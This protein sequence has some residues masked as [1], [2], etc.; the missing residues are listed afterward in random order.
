MCVRKKVLVTILTIKRDAHRSADE[1]A[2]RII[3]LA[4]PPHSRGYRP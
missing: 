4:W 1:V 3:L 2:A